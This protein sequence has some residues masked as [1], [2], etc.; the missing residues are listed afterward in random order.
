M[1]NIK[2]GF[3]IL[4]MALGALVSWFAALDSSHAGP[5]VGNGGG[6]WLCRDYTTFEIRWMQLIDLF[7]ADADYGLQLAEMPKVLDEW[8][9]YSLKRRE[10]ERVSS[11]LHNAIAKSEVDLKKIMHQTPGNGT[12][13]VVSDGYYR[14][15]PDISSCENGYI[16]FGQMANFTDDGRLLLSGAL[17]NDR[18]FGIKDK[19]ALLV[20]EQVYHALRKL[21]GDRNSLRTRAIVAVLFSSL[22]DNDKALRIEKILDRRAPPEEEGTSVGGPTLFT[23]GGKVEENTPAGVKRDGQVLLR[24]DRLLS[25][26][27]GEFQF[28]V[29][30]EALE[31]SPI[32]MEI[33]DAESQTRVHLDASLLSAAFKNNQPVVLSLNGKTGRRAT[34]TCW[35][36]QH[37]ATDESE[38]SRNLLST[39]LLPF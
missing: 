28:R 12:L 23:C 21:D 24:N 7:E 14:V 32:A 19:A 11:R 20:H 25:A 16:Y 13:A 39:K 8:H 3:K 33:I 4:P 26:R 17:W 5:R 22:D 30:T 15:R 2:N 18:S 10:I 38:R 29:L 27:L 37:W 6:V 34:L 31:G 1:M 36:E 35:T 9:L